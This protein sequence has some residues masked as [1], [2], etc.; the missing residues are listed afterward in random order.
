MFRTVDFR[1]RF[2]NADFSQISVLLGVIEAVAYH[3]FVRD[4][5]ADIGH[6]NLPNASLGLIEQRR[7]AHRF[8]LTGLQHEVR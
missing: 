4:L 8:R 1:L 3:E 5:E 2:Q 6:L 7:D